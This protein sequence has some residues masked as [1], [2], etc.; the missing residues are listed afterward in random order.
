MFQDVE[1]SEEAD[2][3]MTI[4]HPLHNT[5]TLW[6]YENDRKK[7]WEENLKEITSFNTVEDF[8]R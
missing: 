7:L 3:E 2:V 4:K 1:K 6:Y 5:W 8:W